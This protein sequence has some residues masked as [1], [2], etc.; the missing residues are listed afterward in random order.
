MTKPYTLTHVLS[1]PVDLTVEVCGNGPPLI[2]SHGLTAN[3]TMTFSQMETLKETFTIIAYDQ[4]GHGQSSPV[5]DPHLYSPRLMADD[6]AAILDE[7]KIDRAVVGGESMGAAIATTFALKHPDR[8]SALLL[9][10]PAFGS[11][12]NNQKAHFLEIARLIRSHGIE[13]FVK[14]ARP[15]WQ[16]Q[17]NLSETGLNRL[18][19]LFLSQNA[20]SLA[21]AMENVIYWVPFYS[22]EE[23]AALHMP[24]KILAWENDPLHPLELARKMAAVIN[25]AQ[26]RILQPANVIFE[27]PRVIGASYSQLLNGK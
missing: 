5:T 22:I 6:I 16:T 20:E 26:L 13:S 27:N 12:P 1:N 17:M 2:F 8:V 15:V 18:S 19:A 7:L 11:R 14:T 24:V 4:R 25:D 3:R 10:A 23:L 21:T 9:T